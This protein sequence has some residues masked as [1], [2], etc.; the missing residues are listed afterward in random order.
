MGKDNKFGEKEKVKKQRNTV[1][2]ESNIRQVNKS[3]NLV[4]IVQ[5]RSAI[6]I[7]ENLSPPPHI[8]DTLMSLRLPRKKL[9]S[10]SKPHDFAREIK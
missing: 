1:I 2:K 9:R 6:S 8:M 7:P 5:K 3:I 10:Q 4:R